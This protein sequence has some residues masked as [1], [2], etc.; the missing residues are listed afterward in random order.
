MDFGFKH[1]LRWYLP[2]YPSCRQSEKK[3]ALA[4]YRPSSAFAVRPDDALPSAPIVVL[5]VVVVVAVVV[6]MMVMV[7]VIAIIAVMMMMMMIVARCLY[8]RVLR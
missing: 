6:M 3:F 5:M 4:Y 1:R 2:Q 7:V 8:V